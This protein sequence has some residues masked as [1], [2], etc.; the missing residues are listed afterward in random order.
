MKKQSLTRMFIAMYG[1]TPHYL[2]VSMKNYVIYFS[3]LWDISFD[4]VTESPI[5]ATPQYIKK[6]CEKL[7]RDTL[8]AAFFVSLLSQYDYAFFETNVEAHTLEH[9]LFDMLSW[10]HMA[11]NYL[12][13]CKYSICIVALLCVI[14]GP[15][16]THH[17]FQKP[18]MKVM[19]SLILS[20]CSLGVSLLY[21]FAY[22]Y[23]TDDVVLNPM[24]KSSSP[25][26]FWG[27]RWNNSV[28]KCLKVSYKILRQIVYFSLLITSSLCVDLDTVLS[29]TTFRMELI[30]QPENTRNQR[31]LALWRHLHIQV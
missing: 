11:N 5:R 14:T 19:L 15:V 6:Q 27:R 16:N 12:T 2:R 4:P 20:Q 17:I 18:S 7:A 24:L 10:R 30:N 9:S 29:A 25:S 13:A 31:W 21:T 1:F 28:H 23:K 3:C 8:L 26:D 22:G